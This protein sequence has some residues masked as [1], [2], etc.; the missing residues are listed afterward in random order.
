M[1]RN[2]SFCDHRAE[3]G[4]YFG[5]AVAGYP[6]AHP[7]RITSDEEANKKAYWDDIAYLKQKVTTDQEG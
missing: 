6:E 1:A 4:D 2:Q 5:I 3:Y 7:D